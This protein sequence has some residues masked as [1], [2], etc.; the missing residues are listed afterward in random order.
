MSAEGTN[1]K[2]PRRARN[3]PKKMSLYEPDRSSPRD[4][5]DGLF[6]FLTFEDGYTAKIFN[7]CDILNKDDKPIA[8]FRDL[9]PGEEVLAR[10]SDNKFYK[11]TVDFTGTADKTVDTKKTTKKG[12]KKRDAAAQRFYN[13]PFLP[14]AGQ[15][16]SAQDHLNTVDQN[17]IQPPTTWPVYQ[18]PPTESF[19]P[20]QPQHQHATAWPQYQ[21]PVSQSS[22]NM[23]QHY[24]HSPF[25]SLYRTTLSPIP[26]NSS[27]SQYSKHHQPHTA[28]PTPSD[29]TQQQP[30]LADLDQRR[31]PPAPTAKESFLK[32][33]YSP[34]THQK[35][36]VLGDQSQ[37][38]TSEHETSSSSA[39]A[40]IIE[41]DP[42]PEYGEPCFIS[43]ESAEDRSW[44]PCE[45][46]K[47]EVEKLVEEKAKLHDVLCGISGEHLEVFRSFLDKVEQ[48]Q[49]QAG[50]WAPKGRSRQQELYPGSG[51][52]L[53]STHLAAIHATAKKDCLRLFHLLFDEFFTAEECQN[54]VA[55]GKHGKVPD[56]KRVLDKFKVNAILTY[57]MRCSTQAGWTPVEKSKV[58]KAFINKCRI[59]ATTL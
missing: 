30:V 12:M 19:L 3:P 34:N 31:Q 56:G 51:L 26:H 15:S 23:Q 42:I 6:V 59:R 45:A 18:P 36:A 22:T 29:Q 35:P 14:Q 27:L 20:V 40:L 9:T 4:D 57:V 58:K 21:L 38:S 13:L 1:T 39:D 49:P 16:T 32:M 17:V 2:L 47:T 54:A 8:C 55:F 44:K 10:W 48:I 25:Q 33:L 50:V 37:T 5:Q 11:A 24:Q 43:P 52:F 28:L 7:L 46:C 41:R 53:S